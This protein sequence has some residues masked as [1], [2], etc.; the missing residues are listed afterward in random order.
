MRHANLVKQNERRSRTLNWRL[1]RRQRDELKELT[2]SHLLSVAR[3]EVRYLDRSF[4][5]THA[6]LLRLAERRRCAG[7]RTVLD[8]SCSDP[9]ADRW[10]FKAIV[11]KSPRSRGFVGY[12]DAHPG[13]VSPQFRGSELR[14]AETRAVSRALRKAYGIGL[15][16]LEELGSG[17]SDSDSH[18]LVNSSNGNHH[19]TEPQVHPPRLRDRLCLLIRKHHLDPAQVRAYAAAFCESPNLRDA[20]RERIES[21]VNHLAARA[22]QDRDALLCQLASYAMPSQEVRP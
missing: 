13:N 16:S 17:P 22:T 19:H 3:G 10:V 5:V 2:R 7:I 9:S 11:Y 14:I 6:G 21:F 18:E 1:S 15:C 4:F 20:S 8:R 12:G